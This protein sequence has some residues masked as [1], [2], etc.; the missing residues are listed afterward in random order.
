MRQGAELPASEHM[1]QDR[2]TG[3]RP[4]GA[5]VFAKV[6]SGLRSLALCGALVF[7]G[8]IL[9]L[10]LVSLRLQEL[11]LRAEHEPAA[12]VSAR[13][14]RWLG[15]CGGHCLASALQAGAV[16]KLSC[17]DRAAGQARRV[18]LEQARDLTE[19]AL[20]RAPFAAEDWARLALIRYRL[21]GDRWTP[22]V[23]RALDQ[24]YEAAPF[25]RTTAAFRT[26]FILS[27]WR[28][29]APPLRRR[30][31]EEL[32]W[33][34]AIDP[35]LARRLAGEVQD[36]VAGMAADLASGRAAASGSAPA[37]QGAGGAAQ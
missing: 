26:A 17:A 13:I 21:A 7:C 35:P 3:A 33:L 34:G 18:W 31:L 14:D 36:P 30:A 24:S 1:G 29:A 2:T 32:R 20:S 12:V 11:A 10:Q 25:A 4:S 37:A 22:A 28:T 5:A 19:R 9:G 23:E 8:L 6:M 27:Q 16:G 15:L